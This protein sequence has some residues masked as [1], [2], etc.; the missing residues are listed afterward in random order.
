[1]SHTLID[2]GPVAE[3]LQGKTLFYGVSGDVKEILPGKNLTAAQGQEEAVFCRQLVYNVSHLAKGQLLRIP[4]HLIAMY[5]EQ[6]T[7]IG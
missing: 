3:Y 4:V 6:I 1:M 2:E 7:A 5:A